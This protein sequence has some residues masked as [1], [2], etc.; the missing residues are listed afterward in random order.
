[1]IVA[2][3]TPTGTVGGKV[4]ALLLDVEGVHVK[5]LARDR[6]KVKHFEE[7]GAVVDEGDLEDDVFV[8]RATRVADALFWATP[9]PPD[10]ED[11]RAF[12]NRLGANAANAITTNRISRVVNLSSFGAHLGFD[13]GPIDGLHDVEGRLDEAAAETGMTAVTHLRPG[14]LMENY[15]LFAR[16]IMEE[17]TIPLPVAGDRQIPTVAAIDVAIEATRQ[18]VFPASERISTK[19][20]HGPHDLGVREAAR[21]IGDALGS[22]VSH[23]RSEPSETKRA[24][25]QLGI[26]GKVA[27]EVVQ[28]FR[29]IENGHLRPAYSR[30]VNSTTQTGFRSFCEAVLAPR[31][32]RELRRKHPRGSS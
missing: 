2:V 30:S 15:F 11:L 5:L 9:T 4:A 28:M 26:G 23:V 8:A 17:G 32:K 22:E 13:T 27:D 6:T 18:L 21:T 25:T 20:L 3:T 12:Q 16:P 31:L 29:S 7:L 14:M 19:P 10:C 1:M 24:L